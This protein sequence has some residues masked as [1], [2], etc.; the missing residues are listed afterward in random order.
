MLV[1]HTYYYYIEDER[2]QAVTGAR[3][4]LTREGH[5]IFKPP[6]SWKKKCAIPIK[7][8]CRKRFR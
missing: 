6:I 8:L 5:Y 4:G 2:S 1:A 7:R 3:R